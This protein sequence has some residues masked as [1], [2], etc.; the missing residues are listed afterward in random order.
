M[1]MPAD[2]RRRAERARM[3]S[4]AG[5]AAL[6]AVWTA[7]LPG[8]AAGHAPRPGESGARRPVAIP[9]AGRADFDGDGLADVVV[10]NAERAD[11]A[12]RREA[13]IVRIY[14]GRRGRAGRRA[15]RL[16]A[17]D[18]LGPAAGAHARD[19][20][21]IGDADGDGR[22]DAAVTTDGPGNRP[23]G[24][25][26]F[27]RAAGASIDLASCASCLRLQGIDGRLAPAGDVNGDGLADVVTT[28]SGEAI[29]VFGRATPGTIDVSDPAVPALRVRGAH[30]AIE[31]SV[32]G[33]GDLDGDHRD[34][35]GVEWQAPSVAWGEPGWPAPSD[36][37]IVFG[38]AD[39]GTVDL[40]SATSRTLKV[41]I[42][43]TDRTTTMRAAGDLDGDG[44]A[45]L[46][47]GNIGVGG[48]GCPAA[49]GEYTTCE[50]RAWVAYGP[51]A[52][53]ALDVSTASRRVRG[54]TPAGSAPSEF[55]D[56]PQ[57]VG[58]VNGDGRPDLAVGTARGRTA[59][60]MFA[61]A[62]RRA[63]APTR[64]LYFDDHDRTLL[65]EPGVSASA[66]GDV[67]GDRFADLLAVSSVFH[68]DRL[69][70]LSW[71]VLGGPARATLD[72]RRPGRAALRLPDLP[73]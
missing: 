71:L 22:T 10:G 24:F 49:P 7:G 68:G 62:A 16:R 1:H 45:D 30:K 8:S 23:L 43:D 19:P 42:P 44:H 56:A 36:L 55:G 11:A 67:N 35:I 20:V 18:V 57:G 15:R 9:L 14:R 52:P 73:G 25:V 59:R 12:G 28:A 69:S 13:G 5:V 40:G 27:G 33:V 66:V 29:V 17:I 4:C 64:T 53:G 51:L 2:V 60:V 31:F 34:D 26:I 48:D 72:L 63:A 3:P 39:P 32:H 50:G 47:L 37:T 58:D 61:T 70:I 41:Q 38:R 21:L 54:F 46:A 65:G 6:A